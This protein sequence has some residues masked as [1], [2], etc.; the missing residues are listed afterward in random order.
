MKL[1]GKY[2]SCH[3]IRQPAEDTKGVL[4]TEKMNNRSDSFPKPRKDMSEY[5][6][7]DSQCRKGPESFFRILLPLYTFRQ[8]EEFRRTWCSISGLH[9]LYAE[10]F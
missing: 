2:L 1:P 6:G 3:H 9:Q 4:E 5:R 10:D 7:S 8:P